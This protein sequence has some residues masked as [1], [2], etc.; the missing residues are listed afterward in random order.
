MKTHDCEGLL[1]VRHPLEA[2]T[3]LREII[4]ESIASA[5][6]IRLPRVDLGPLWAARAM[7]EIVQEGRSTVD[8]CGYISRRLGWEES[9]GGS[10]LE[11][12]ASTS[13]R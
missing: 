13:I 5:P 12:V 1:R 11:K 8:G 10:I 2:T 6:A 9:A 4:D 3:S 7:E